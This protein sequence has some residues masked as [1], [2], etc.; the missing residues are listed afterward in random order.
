MGIAA[1]VLGHGAMAELGQPLPITAPAEV[2][3]SEQKPAMFVFEAKQAGGL[4]LILRSDSG[5]DVAA[6]LCDDT[7]Q[8]VYYGYLDG[9][10]YEHKG[11]EQGMLPI[12]RS[13]VY[14]LYIDSLKGSGKVSVLASVM[15]QPLNA[16]PEDPLGRPDTA[17]AVELG[18]WMSESIRPKRGDRRDWYVIDS[19]RKGVLTAALRGQT[20]VDLTLAL[21]TERELRK[22]LVFANQTSEDDRGHESATLDVTE[23]ERV[24]LRVAGWEERDAGDYRLLVG[25]VEDSSD[26]QPD[27]M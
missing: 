12:P 22:P 9:D 1:C 26:D 18:A 23:G 8:A 6:E 16:I 19:P 20:G 14:R 25:F 10:W 15:Q 7:G 27:D 13:G 2:M 11:W 24:Y 5:V 4:G 21:F 3:V 17:A